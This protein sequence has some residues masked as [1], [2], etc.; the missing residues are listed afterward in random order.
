MWFASYLYDRQFFVENN[1][2]VLKT[3]EIAD[4]VP[5]GS[6]LGPPS[7][8]IGYNGWWSSWVGL[9]IGK[10]LVKQYVSWYG[11][12]NAIY[13]NT[14]SKMINCDFLKSNFRKTFRKTLHQEHTTMCTMWTLL[15]NQNIYLAL[16]T[17][18]A[19]YLCIYL[20]IKKLIQYFFLNQNTQSQNIISQ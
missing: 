9:C 14:A 19:T 2:N 13:C 12:Y 3:S 18:S 1:E 20:I 17:L 10:K 5:H 16:E 8:G 6:I 7:I 15:F 4:G 11:G